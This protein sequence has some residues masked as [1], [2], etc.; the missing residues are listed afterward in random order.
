MLPTASHRSTCEY[1]SSSNGEAK[2]FRPIKNAKRSKRVK[3][4]VR[5]AHSTKEPEEVTIDWMDT[6]GT[7]AVFDY[8][9]VDGKTCWAYLTQITNIVQRRQEAA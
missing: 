9:D 8:R 7:R 3:V 2:C 5:G 6:L 1:R 4:M